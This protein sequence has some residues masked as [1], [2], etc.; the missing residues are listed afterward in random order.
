MRTHRKCLQDDPSYMYVPPALDK[1]GE[2]LRR[3]H[4]SQD[5]A[6][7]GTAGGQEGG[8]KQQMHLNA[9]N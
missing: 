5:D 3:V 4:E 2:Q 6:T 1:E 9:N 7:K 8:R